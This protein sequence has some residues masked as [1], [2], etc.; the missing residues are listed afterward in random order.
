M[1]M[2][3]A[4]R[5]KRYREK[6]GKKNLEQLEKEYRQILKNVHAMVNHLT[7]YQLYGL[8]AFL[9]SLTCAYKTKAEREKILS[10]CAR[11]H[12]QVDYGDKDE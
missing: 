7:D 5:Q 11:I 12:A 2:T 4:E 6:M 10:M 1:A 8:E 9:Y 3:N